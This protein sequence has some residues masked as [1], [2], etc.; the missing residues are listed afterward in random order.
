MKTTQITI[1]CENRAGLPLGILGEH[2][3]AAHIRH[4]DET[5][6]LDTGQGM[7]L[8]PNAN[9]LGL[10][11]S[12]LDHIVISHGHYDHTGG[13]T[14]LPPQETETPLHAHPGIF[15]AKF[16]E[17]APGR[18]DIFIGTGIT[19][20]ELRERLNIQCDLKADLTEIAPGVWFSGQ[21]PRTTDFEGPDP[22][23][24]LKTE[25][26][27]ETD[28]LLDDIALLFETGSGPVIAAGCAHSGIVN[29]M[30]Y[31]SKA[32]GLDEFH[33][34]LGG[35]H[36]GFSSD[37]TQLDRTIEAFERFN[38]QKIAVS[39]CTGNLPAAKLCQHFGS[40]FAFA[41]AGW[42]VTF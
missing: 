15:G 33:A 41:D 12:R 22:E 18:G 11:F 19:P 14:H 42:Q 25:T 16:L 2:G 17:P 5:F 7:A 35:T 28:L 10:D 24:T 36:L 27:Y 23:L 32:L 1:V 8:M 9:T 26:G 3:F 29:I 13:L 40:R 20:E 4:N 21:V 30:A 31:F 38:V 39:H 37:P 34:V 6:L